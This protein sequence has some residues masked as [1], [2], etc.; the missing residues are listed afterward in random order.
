MLYWP[1]VELNPGCLLRRQIVMLSASALFLVLLGGVSISDTSASRRALQASRED[2]CVR[3]HSA[4]SMPAEM[5]NRF[6]EW[7]ASAHKAAGV[8]CDKCHG[9]DAAARDFGR[10]H[11]GVFPPSNK[12]STLHEANAPDTCGRCHA[13][14]VNSF[15]E[16]DHYQ[17]LKASGLG[18]SCVNCHPH[19]G[20][21]AART[22]LE[23]ESLCTFCHNTLNGL[24]PQRPDIVK[25][26]KSTLDAIG[27]TNHMVA[28]ID[29]L[30]AQAEKKKLEATEEKEDFRLIKI[31][32]AEAKTGWH[33]F[34]MEAPAV[35]AEK[36]FDEAVKIKD[37]LSKKL[38]RD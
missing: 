36:S 35:K 32:L 30:L 22:P 25:K 4:L 38:G 7:R 31:S 19:M 1:F 20:S 28:W 26:A 3:C 6:L 13:A 12:R 24:L 17:K 5:S 11:A 37:K 14:V 29:Q 16:S 34:K 8:S 33:T 23:G 15:I 21:F 18:P 10:A 27:R 2:G 9:G